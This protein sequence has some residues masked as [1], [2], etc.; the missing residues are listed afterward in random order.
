MA[1]A[2]N[3]T[4]RPGNWFAE[5][6]RWHYS[7]TT[8]SLSANVGH[9]LDQLAEGF[10]IVDRK[11]TVLFAN[12]AV[13]E[14]M[15]TAA[16]RLVNRHVDS[17]AWCSSEPRRF[18][19]H[20]VINTENLRTSPAR[21]TPI[22]IGDEQLLNFQ[23]DDE[24]RRLLAINVRPF[25]DASV[26]G[27]IVISIRDATGVETYRAEME[28]LLAR[29]RRSREEVQ[30]C[31]EQLRHLASQD[32]LTGCRNRGSLDNQLET[33]WHESVKGDKQLSCMMI[34]I[35]HFKS[36]NDAHGHATGDEVLRRVGQTLRET[37]AGVGQVYR[38]GGEEFC[39]LLPGH[40]LQAARWIGE[41]VRAAISELQVR[42]E[43]ATQT[44]Q[45]SVSIGVNDRESHAQNAVQMIGGADKCLYMAKRHGR[46]CVVAYGPE[47][48]AAK[49]RSRDAG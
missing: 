9:V 34:D 40:D 22:A 41:R 6:N 4:Q 38:Y 7:R 45:V 35:D 47:V 24:S 28:N 25:L 14:I 36:F 23:R 29:V 31:N 37:F 10:L 18:P 16:T 32:A 17:L 19:W 20:D 3:E 49:F 43:T 26:A 27:A 15:G 44:L 42:S 21:S 1:A 2:S 46:N 5:L 13:A 30:E 48:A 8:P 39:V 11:L 33:I 12:Q